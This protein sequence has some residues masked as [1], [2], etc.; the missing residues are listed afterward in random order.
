MSTTATRTVLLGDLVVA[1]FDEAEMHGI[2]RERIPSVAARVVA[3]ILRGQPEVE[4]RIGA[5]ERSM[6]RTRLGRAATATD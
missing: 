4:R 3:N 5:A 6:S 2:Q 1:A